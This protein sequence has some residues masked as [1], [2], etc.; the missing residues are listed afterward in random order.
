MLVID[1]C[2]QQAGLSCFVLSFLIR[3]RVLL[4]KILNVAAV[5]SFSFVCQLLDFSRN[6]FRGLTQL[7]HLVVCSSALTDWERTF[8]THQ[9][10]Y[11]LLENSLSC[12][13]TWLVDQIRK[14]F[15]YYMIDVN[16]TFFKHPRISDSLNSFKSKIHDFSFSHFFADECKCIIQKHFISWEKPLRKNIISSS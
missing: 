1:N 7:P 12:S 14:I 8:C 3:N 2:P 5:I 10:P 15:F 4:S 6:S 16:R 9:S 11:F 13:V